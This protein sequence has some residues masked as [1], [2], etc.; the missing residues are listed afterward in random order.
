MQVGFLRGK[1][2]TH[3]AEEEEHIS[4]WH[5]AAARSKRREESACNVLRDERM[6]LATSC[7]LLQLTLMVMNA[8]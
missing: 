2:I 6:L 1:S 4:P 7:L 3:D 8:E 5:P